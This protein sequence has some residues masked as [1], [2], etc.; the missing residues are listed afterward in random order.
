M[1]KPTF[2]LCK[3]PLSTALKLPRTTLPP[4][5]PLPSPHIASVSDDLYAWQSSQSSRPLFVLHDGPPYAN[6]DLHLGHALNK[7]LK[8]F[9]CRVNL[10]R[11]NRV[12]YT[13]GWDC[14]G[15][16]IEIKAIQ[17]LSESTK[18]DGVA[19]RTAARAFAAQTA[20][21]Q[22]DGFREWGVMGDWSKAYRTMDAEYGARQLNIWKGMVEKGL[23]RRAMRPVYWSASSGTALAEAELEYEDLV[24]T[25][26]TVWV[27]LS[28]ECAREV[29]LGTEGEL[30]VAVWTTTPWTLPA[31][32]AVA[33]GSGIEYCAVKLPESVTRGR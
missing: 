12:Q 19:V 16:P 28:Q 22:R 5:P 25:T 4:R 3:H 8:D 13:P 1:L 30:G 7:I 17:S 9:I 6:G 20:Q 11:G 10:Q 33:V 18:R 2:P 21:T 23:V 14:H 32:R 26:A 29:L 31:N 24:S 27:K 15:L